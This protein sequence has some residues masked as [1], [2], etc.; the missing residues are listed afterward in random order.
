MGN[1]QNAYIE[2]KVEKDYSE[3]NIRAYSNNKY[4]HYIPVERQLSQKKHI[5]ELLIKDYNN[6]GILYKIYLIG[7]YL[8]WG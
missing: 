8:L 4:L 3:W 6:S 1:L 2:Y 5:R 7:K